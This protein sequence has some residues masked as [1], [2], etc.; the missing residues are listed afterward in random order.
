MQQ[1]S[2][3][4]VFFGDHPQANGHT[5]SMVKTLKKLVVTTN[6]DISH[7]EF[8]RGFLEL[9]N[10]PQ[11]NG[12]NSECAQIDHK[13]MYLRSDDYYNACGCPLNVLQV[14]LEVL[15]Q[16]NNT[17]K[18]ESTAIVLEKSQYISCQLCSHWGERVL[19]RNRKHH[20]P[21]IKSNLNNCPQPSHKTPPFEVEGVHWF[22]VD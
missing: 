14:G 17:K 1:L 3:K 15:V 12:W 8:I 10:T 16:N 13:D 5:E 19:W 18:W 2:L 22:P 11:E 6:K 21:K 20:R 7:N 4:W 9:R